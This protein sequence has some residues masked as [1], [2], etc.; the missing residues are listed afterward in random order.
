MTSDPTTQADDEFDYVPSVVEDCWRGTFGG[1]DEAERVQALEEYAA[2]IDYCFNPKDGDGAQE[3]LLIGAMLAAA[4]FVASL[5]CTCTPGDVGLTPPY[6]W[7]IV[8]DV[9]SPAIEE[10]DAANAEFI[11]HARTDLEAALAMLDA[12]EALVKRCDKYEATGYPT[13][14]EG[15]AYADGKENGVSLVGEWLRAILEGN[16]G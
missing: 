5:P 14:S 16:D 7:R 9:E 4:S 1:Y 2:A 6:P 15:A 12:I 3:S 10:D 13:Y 8:C 11:A